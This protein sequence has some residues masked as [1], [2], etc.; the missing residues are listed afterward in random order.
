MKKALNEAEQAATS[1]TGR[2]RSQSTVTC[3]LPSSLLSF[4]LFFL[5]CTL[6]TRMN[7][8]L[9]TLHIIIT[10]HIYMYM[11]VIVHSFPTVYTANR[12]MKNFWLLKKTFCSGSSPSSSRLMCVLVCV[13]VDRRGLK[14]EISQ[15]KFL[16]FGASGR[17]LQL[18]EGDQTL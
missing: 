13:V 8:S 3:F 11:Y 9:S 4:F 10:H 17:L 15:A 2:E 12:K 16:L 18:V 1:K 7:A 5:S 14:R 6:S